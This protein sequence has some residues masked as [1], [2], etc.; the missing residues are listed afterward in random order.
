[1]SGLVVHPL[2]AMGFR[3]FF[4]LGTLLAIVSVPAWIWMFHTGTGTPSY[5][6]GLEWH[7]HEMLFGYT[8][9]IVAGFLLTAVS[10]WTGRPTASGAALLGLATLWTAGRLVLLGA[11][12][13]PPGIVALVDCAF[14]PCLAWVVGRPLVATRSWRNL[15]FVPLLSLMALANLGIHLEAGGWIE[16]FSGR[17]TAVAL[18]AIT[19]MMVFL[20]GRVIPYFASR[21]LGPGAP[22][23]PRF[24]GIFTNATAALVLVLDLSGAPAR[25]VGAAAAAAGILCLLRLL[26]WRHA[27]IR[28]LPL[29][30][31]L[32]L[33]YAWVGLALALRGLAGP[34]LGL[35]ERIAT[36]ALTV[37]GI[38]TLTVGMMVRVSLGH[39]GRLLQAPSAA[40]VA[41]V[42]ITLAALVRTS[43]PVIAPQ[44][45]LESLVASSILW[46]SAFVLLAWV[47]VPI[48]TRPRVDGRPG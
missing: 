16:G 19:V 20:G 3:T 36:H 45:Y 8:T 7:R 34:W 14:L 27:G 12:R 38:G 23:D 47:L 11:D 21:A 15:A 42:L 32:Y 2:L 28:G 43:A 33:G 29:L 46:S 26:S 40:V 9:A 30:W 4:F 37:G 17:A 44:R 41:F 25:L 39:T 35:P 5:L 24:L 6:P 22:V 13:I 48:V 31:V 18:D 1:M 10:N